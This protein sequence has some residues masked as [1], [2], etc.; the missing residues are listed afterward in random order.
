MDSAE[1]TSDWFPC[2]HCGESVRQDAKVCRHCGATEDCG[3]NDTACDDDGY[4]AEDDF[5]YDEYLDRE[6]GSK[7]ESPSEAAS[8]NWGIRLVILAIL[9][10]WLLVYVI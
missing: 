4:P 10:S 7:Y 3:W 2:P 1:L 6:F 5:D 8:R 9:L